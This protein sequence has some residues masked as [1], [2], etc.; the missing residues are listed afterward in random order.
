MSETIKPG[1]LRQKLGR[2]LD[3]VEDDR[4]QFVI[5]RRGRPLAAL[6]PYAKYQRL[7]QAAER[8]ILRIL[9]RDQ[10]QLTRQQIADLSRRAQRKTLTEPP[11]RRDSSSDRDPGGR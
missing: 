11:R 1:D 6:V 10:R 9:D 2:V 3:R 8:D 7:E 4:D 5:E